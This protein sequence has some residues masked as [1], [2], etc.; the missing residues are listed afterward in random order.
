VS[1]LSAALVV[2]H[3]V[4]AHNEMASPLVATATLHMLATTGQLLPVAFL[5]LLINSHH[6]EPKTFGG[7]GELRIVG[8]Q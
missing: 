2:D 3:P 8:Q 5:F 4:P 1:A 6:L 7:G